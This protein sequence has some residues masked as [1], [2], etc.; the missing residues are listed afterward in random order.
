MVDG[1]DETAFNQALTELRFDVAEG[2]IAGLLPERRPAL[3]VRLAAAREAAQERARR[4]ATTIQETSSRH[5]HNRLHAIASAPDTAPLLALLPEVNRR[6]SEILLGSGERWGRRQTEANRRRLREARTAL[7]RFDV[8]LARGLLT[9]LDATFL[10][11]EE[12]EERDQLLLDLTSRSM[13]MEQLSGAADQ[14]VADG[15]T[16][17]RRW[18]RRG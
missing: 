4:L 6:Q 13:E 1:H 8:E 2:L 12:I 14:I 10:G 15:R 18:W 17:R 11:D 3:E 9:R 7:D 16:A 5:D